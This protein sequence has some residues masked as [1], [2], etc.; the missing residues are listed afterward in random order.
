MLRQLIAGLGR[1]S[2]PAENSVGLAD[3]L[4]EVERLRQELANRAAGQTAAQRHR[5]ILVQQYRGIVDAYDKAI[6]ALAGGALGVS[7]AFVRDLAPELIH[8]DLLLAAW[9]LV[10]VSLG[11]I[12]AGFLLSQH[13]YRQM[14][15]AMDAGT[16]AKYK[17]R[18][19][20]SVLVMRFVAGLTLL[21]GVSILGF[22]IWTNLG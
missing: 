19:G 17:G 9:I 13:R 2:P 14:I 16:D 22:F 1:S 6:M 3:A 5:E 4:A 10:C 20:K 21:L 15:L 18:F 11:T 12:V 8:R 7:F